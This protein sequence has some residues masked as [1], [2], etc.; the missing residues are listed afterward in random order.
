VHRDNPIAALTMAE[1]GRVFAGEVTRWGQLGATG[2]WV[3]RPIHACGLEHTTALAYFIQRAALDG[4]ALSTTMAAF[5]QSADV[6]RRVGEDALS[7]GF[8]AAMRTNPEVRLVPIAARPGAE[9]VL[10]TPESIV[11]DRYPLDRFLLVYVRPP[12]SPFAREFLRLMLS[13]EGQAAVAASPQG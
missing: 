6:V 9:A 3:G 8:A 4:R 7:I 11:E 1:V 13:R 10:P 2:E 12:I 5:P